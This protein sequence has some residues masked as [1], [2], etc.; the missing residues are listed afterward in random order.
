MKLRYLEQRED[1][2]EIFKVILKNI[3]EHFSSEDC[4]SKSISIQFRFNKHLNLI[5][6]EYLSGFELAQ[7]VQDYRHNKNFVKQLSQRTYVWLA[8]SSP[9]R[10]ILSP[11]YLVDVKVPRKMLRM[12]FIHIVIVSE[13]SISIHNYSRVCET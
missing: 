7:C 11:R 13:L 9:I 8:L 1:F 6:P 12:I 10:N 3:V 4:E 2:R 5:F